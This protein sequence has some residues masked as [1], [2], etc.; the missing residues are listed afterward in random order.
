MNKEEPF[1]WIFS[2]DISQKKGFTE[3]VERITLSANEETDTKSI[4]FE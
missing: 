3:A 2:E 1:L 4:L